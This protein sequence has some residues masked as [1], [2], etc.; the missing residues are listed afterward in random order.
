MIQLHTLRRNSLLF[1]RYAITAVILIA[2]V[3][4]GFAQQPLDVKPD[5]G[6]M[7][8]LERSANA[9]SSDGPVL[10]PTSQGSPQTPGTAP[11][12]AAAG[13]ANA[14]G[15]GQ[16][17]HVLDQVGL[18]PADVTALKEKAASGEL[19][20]NEI[21][22]I[23]L[24]LIGKRMAPGDLE[25]AL[26]LLGVT[27]T[28]QQLA[29]LKSCM[30]LAQ[31]AT[32][33]QS[34][35]QTVSNGAVT[36]RRIAN[37]DQSDSRETQ[38][39]VQVSSIEKNFRNLDS[40]AP[41][42][43]PTAN[44]LVQFGYSLFST[45]VSTFAPADNVPVDNNYVIGPGDELNVQIWGRFTSKLSLTV[46]R[47]GSV[48]IPEVGP[49]Q[50]AGLTFADARKLIDEREG[51]I[52]GVRVDVTLGKLRSVQ[53]FVVGEVPQP[54]AYTV[55]A[56]ARVSNALAASGGITKVGSLRKIELRRGNQIVRTIDLYD[57]LIDGR[58]VADERLQ[59]NDVIFVPV[60]GPVIAMTG[61]V[62]RP[63][64]YELSAR[65]ENLE[66]VL[67]LGGGIGA[68]GY[69]Q[70]LQVE[71][72]DLHEKR[73]ALDIDLNERRAKS[74][75]LHDG[76]LLR[77]YPVLPTRRDVVM[78]KGNVNRPGRYQ[79]R[80]G[81]RV[82]DLVS[83][84]EGVAPHTY[85]GY[86][87]VRRIEGREKTE[88]IVPV[89]LA[90]ALS[91]PS[92]PSAA[93]FQLDPLD[94]LT[95]L[96][97]YDLK[98]LPTVQVFGEVRKPG[99]FVLSRDMRV[100]DL[101]YLAGGLREEAYLKSAELART[102]VVDG[103]HTV[104]INED[105]DLRAA[106]DRVAG[107]NPSLR[108]NDQLF[109]R[110]ASDWH[111]PWVVTLKGEVQ[112]PGP[113]SVA[114]GE[115]I[116]S[117][118]DR[119]GG[120]RSDAYLPATVLLRQSIKVAEQKQLDEARARLRAQL[121]KLQANPQTQSVNVPNMPNVPGSLAAADVITRVL[122]ESA[123]QEAQ[124]RLVV[125]LHP[126]EHLVNTPDDIALADQDVLTIPRR[127]VSINVFGQVYRPSAFA[128]RS[129]TMVNQYLEMAGGPNE[130][131]DDDHVMVLKADGST[132]TDAGLKAGREASLFPLLP[133]MSGGLMGQ[134]L[135]P[136]DTVYVPEKLNYINN[137]QSFAYI[138][139]IVSQSISS[140]A[141]IGLLAANL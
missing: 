50:V 57:L 65:E 31:P 52:T 55:S 99:F 20:P 36:S 8:T 94:E 47:D 87:T 35:Q 111:L 82:A 105:I 39:P 88:H 123:G 130:S 21:Q 132:L 124:G 102:E 122:A 108:A 113:Y 107:Q 45:K 119:A 78:V 11:S 135:E 59:P 3:T 67:K 97:E 100:S 129:S 40:G 104:H 134:E 12:S 34:I 112:R 64:I 126:G 14:M 89:D 41:P 38:E 70:R 120:L 25:G 42:Q 80:P 93:N 58:A 74:F 5:S 66:R 2:S 19:S 106:L 26:R 49:L 139:T 17:V 22:D 84:A 81:M 23:C 30:D 54:G 92:A 51:Q 68:F 121:L 62:K 131:A 115:R 37:A 75:M 85:F 95:V 24:H 127:P 101:I 69:S 83:E 32:V 73:V 91:D 9:P 33:P 43:A 137:L 79:W 53:V 56:L 60:I 141:V 28:S 72:V 110:R 46:G 13:L 48:M 136:G 86:A 125:H 6:S 138:S 103:S 44:D 90:A 109:V 18:P 71:R 1:V 140:L 7:T 63:A 133:V 114:E 29:Q 116:S 96:G 61:D 117:L 118:I 10:S 15:P 76:D 77:I 4:I 27:I 16:A 128:Y 98:Y